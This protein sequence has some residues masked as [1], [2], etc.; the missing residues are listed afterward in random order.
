MR[1][2]CG[3]WRLWAIAATV[4]VG[5]L[6]APAAFG[7]SPGP[8]LAVN[9]AADHHAISPYIYGMNFA[10]AGLAN[11]LDLPVDRWGGNTTDTY[12]WKIGS[13]NTGNDYFFENIPDCFDAPTYTCDDGPKYGYR[14]FVQKDRS[15]GA[16]SLMTLPMMGWV[17][18]DGKPDHPFTCGFPKS[19]FSNQDRFDQYDPNCGD[20]LQGGNE[21]ASNPS[22]DGMKIGASF[23]GDW[24]EKLV[25]LYGSAANGGVR[26]Y[27]LG[28]EPA[29]WSDTHRDMHPAPETYDELWQKSRD[30]GATVRAADPG[31]KVLGFSEWGW[32]NYFCSAADHTDSGCFASS[33]DRANHGGTPLVEWFLQ[34]MRAYQ[35]L[36]GKRL[37]D[38]L[39]LHYYAQGGNSTDV[40]RSLWDPTYTDPSWINDEIRLIPR[41]KQWVAQN[42]PGTKLALSEYNLSVGDATTNA[43]IQA[44]TLG[45]FAREGVDLAT[46][47]EMDDDGPLIPDAFRMYRN[48]NGNH[49]KFGNTWVRST[50]ANQSKLAVYGARRSGDGAYTILVINK[51][52]GALESSLSL[53]GIS[54]SGSAQVWRWTGG[55]ISH[56]GNR[57]VPAGGFTATYPGRS[58]TL[59]VIPA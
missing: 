20:G 36:H 23:D 28:N 53:S 21:L 17:A 54:P 43:L 15:I 39:D 13:S 40:T 22:R 4:G 57:S 26:F 11:Q 49:S 42:Y 3:A 33:P 18:K 7:A 38:Y 10:P 37:I 1:R 2:T 58:L 35:Q 56:V 8:A 19:V 5:L 16:K 34:K 32:P 50:S 30:Y 31:A 44:D 55:A 24:V 59:F 51:T 25:S 45:I 41:M 9:G 52:G 46:R 27:E 48:Y 14:Q 6:A 29:L 47:W 12:N